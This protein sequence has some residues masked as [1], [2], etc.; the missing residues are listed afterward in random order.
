LTAIL[1]FAI[2]IGESPGR[3]HSCYRFRRDG[4]FWRQLLR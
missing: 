4:I 2:G 1:S 3:P